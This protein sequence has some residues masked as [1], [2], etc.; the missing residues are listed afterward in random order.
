MRSHSRNTGA[1]IASRLKREKDRYRHES[2]AETRNGDPRRGHARYP[3]R[4]DK[5]SGNIKRQ[6]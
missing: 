3:G 6:V 4:N 2:D 1:T 5:C